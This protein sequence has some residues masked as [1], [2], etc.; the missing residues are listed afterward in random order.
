MPSGSR[1]VN[2]CRS[3]IL[4][5]KLCSTNSSCFRSVD[6]LPIFQAPTSPCVQHLIALVFFG[7]RAGL[8][9]PGTRQFDLSEAGTTSTYRSHQADPSAACVPLYIIYRGGYEAG[10]MQLQTQSL[11]S[12]SRL[13]L[14]VLNALDG[15]SLCLLSIL[16]L[17]CLFHHHASSCQTLFPLR[18][19]SARAL[20]V[21]VFKCE[22]IPVAR[23]SR[24]K[25]FVT[26]VNLCAMVG[27]VNHTRQTSRQGSLLSGRRKNHQFAFARDQAQLI[28]CCSTNLQ[29]QSHP[30]EFVGTE[31]I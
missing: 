26:A 31:P 10:V 4:F 16:V 22:S 14:E 2:G 21:A 23:D 8:F 29:Q 25:I 20:R 27:S 15:A 30:P 24:S 1:V 17:A 12:G 6:P 13:Q 19:G 18:N 9:T 28:A 3:V 7:L 5:D 11:H